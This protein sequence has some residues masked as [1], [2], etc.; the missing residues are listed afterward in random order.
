MKKLMAM[1]F[2]KGEIIK[3]LLNKEKPQIKYNK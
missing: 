3:Q 2:Y 1:A